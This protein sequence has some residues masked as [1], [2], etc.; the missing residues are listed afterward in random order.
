MGASILF[1]RPP[2]IAPVMAHAIAM[3]PALGIAYLASS[4]RK[5]GIGDIHVLDALGEDVHQRTKF[6]DGKFYQYGMTQEQISTKVRNN[7]REVHILAVSIMFSHEWPIAKELICRLK[8][9]NPHFFIICGGEHVTAAPEFCLE[10]CPEIDLCVLG[11][12]DEA[13][14]EVVQAFSTSKN[15]KGIDGIV[16]NVGQGQIY[17]TPARKRIKDIDNIAWPDWKSLP[18]D[19]YLDNHLGYGTDSVRSM[20][21]LATRGCPYKCTFCS[22]PKMWTTRW[23]M[24]DYQDVI[25]E[26]EYYIQ[27]YKVSNFDFYDLTTIIRKDWL[28]NFCSAI[29][30]KKW[31]ITWEMPAGSRSEAMDA[32]TLPLMRESGCKNLSYAPES[33]SPSVLVKIK[34]KVKLDRMKASMSIAVKNGINIKANMIFGFPHETRR[35]I[36]QTF[37][38]LFTMARIGVHDVYISCFAPYPGS[39]LYDDLVKSREIKFMDANYFLDLMT[40]SD[41]SFSRSFAKG[42]GD[43]ELMVYRLGGMGFFYLVSYL[44]RPWRAIKSVLNLF[45]GRI[46]SRL[47]MA[48]NQR[49]RGN[50]SKFFGQRTSP[51]QP[52]P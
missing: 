25:R 52:N 30:E 6:M 18:I 45:F 4:L 27:T 9:E 29:I 8:K 23:I 21:L 16:F 46:E 44:F 40:Y 43:R 32:D 12:G 49:I 28:V 11:E 24:R 35:E 34:K 20:P 37:K 3:C 5:Q 50:R 33:G 7:Y 15:W 41:L 39:E 22:N 14:V 47:E 38:F 42:I 26:M 31:N 48:L 1:L 17:R 2:L 51:Q 10:D 19:V 36:F 13:I